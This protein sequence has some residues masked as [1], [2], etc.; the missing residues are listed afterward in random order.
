[1]ALRNAGFQESTEN[2]QT[3]R[4]EKKDRKEGTR[5]QQTF[6]KWRVGSV[7]EEAPQE[8]WKREPMIQKK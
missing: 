2:Q 4:F 8:L 5:G 6:F 7:V 1:M 3:C